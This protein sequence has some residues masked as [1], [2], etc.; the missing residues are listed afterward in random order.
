[1]ARARLEVPSASYTNEHDA[2]RFVRNRKLKSTGKSL[3]E[4]MANS[5]EIKDLKAHGKLKTQETWE[6]RHKFLRFTITSSKFVEDKK[7]F[8]KEVPNPFIE[9]YFQGELQQKH[10]TSKK[11]TIRDML[12]EDVEKPPDK[13][14]KGMPECK[15]YKVQ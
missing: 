1:M 11:P 15:T 9:L 2:S 6:G 5:F 10:L 7:R 13:K 14:K 4:L 12:V 3:A 8:P